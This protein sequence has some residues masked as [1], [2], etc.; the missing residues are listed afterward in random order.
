MEV[1][2]VIRLEIITIEDNRYPEQLKSIENP[3]KK[4]YAKGNIKLLKSNIISIIGSRSCSENGI[5]LAHKFSRELV[6]QGI[7]IA[8]GMAL[9]IDTVAHQ[10]TIQE[11]GN[12]IAVLGNGLKHIFPTENL[13]LYQ[14]IIENNGLVITEYPPEEKA[15]SSHFLERNRIVSGL[16]L[17]ILVIEAAYRS[18]TSITAKLAQRQGRKVFALPHEVNDLHG[19][20]TNKLIQKGAKMIT[21]TEDIIKEF[22]FL[23]YKTPP[24]QDTRR[25]LNKNNLSTRLSTNPAKKDIKLPLCRKTCTNQSYHEIYQFITEKPVSLNELYKHSN[26][27]ISEINN[28]LLML[29]LEGYIKKVVGGYICILDKK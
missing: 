11:N 20:G 24:K 8:S 7:T 17:G 18:G 9:G 29:E 23:Q 6:Y 2:E 16:S 22:P 21:T 14:Q 25:S 26:K 5:Q 1:Q 28:I 10:T 15:K 3:P 4:L 27:S 19:V 13:K 12:T